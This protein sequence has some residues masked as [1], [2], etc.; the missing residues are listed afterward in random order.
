M[1]LPE[2]LMICPRLPEA[3]MRRRRD[4]FVICIVASVGLYPS[5]IP[6]PRI[7]PSGK[8]GRGVQ[9]GG[10]KVGGRTLKQDES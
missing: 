6:L 2:C 1:N 9:N 7:G 5:N 3:A 8:Y 4:F 10:E